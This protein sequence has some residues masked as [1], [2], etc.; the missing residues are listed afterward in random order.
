MESTLTL[1]HHQNSEVF[2]SVAPAEL[3]SVLSE[4]PMVADCAV[5]GVTTEDGEELPR[6]EPIFLAVLNIVADQFQ[7]IYYS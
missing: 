2:F 3:E 4:H 6:S 7:S 5:I 1:P